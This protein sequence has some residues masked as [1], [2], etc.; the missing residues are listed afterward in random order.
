MSAITLYPPVPRTT[1]QA[2]LS[3]VT[4]L[5]LPSP[6]GTSGDWHF[7]PGPLAPTARFVL[8]GEHVDAF[9]NTNP[10]LGEDGVY[11]CTRTLER[12][13][14][15][16]PPGETAFAA[17]HYRAMCDRLVWQVRRSYHALNFLRPRDC[18]D[19]DAQL[20]ELGRWID[21]LIGQAGWPNSADV[22]LCAWRKAHH[23]GG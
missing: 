6:E 20:A 15:S 1:P 14:N 16:I 5:N 10:L 8:A 7:L 19:T 13:G 3:G 12:L 23:L 9:V 21:R 4:A 2:Y 17:N 22:F 11:D 18:F